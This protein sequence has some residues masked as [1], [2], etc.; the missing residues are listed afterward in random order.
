MAFC[1][2]RSFF[3]EL[4]HIT[5][6]V[7]NRLLRISRQR[8]TNLPIYD[9]AR[10]IN[11]SIA[12]KFGKQWAASACGAQAEIQLKCVM[13]QQK[14]SWSH[15]VSYNFYKFGNVSLLLGEELV[16]LQWANAGG[17]GGQPNLR[18][19]SSGPYTAAHV[20]SRDRSCPPSVT[21]VMGDQF[22]TSLHLWCEKEEC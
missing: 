4:Q 18:D 20:W 22:T 19:C 12:G 3:S 14:S 7:E 5:M 9:M 1:T 17:D 2:K 10:S 15:Q 21:F 13:K 6:L 11:N 16:S 8:K